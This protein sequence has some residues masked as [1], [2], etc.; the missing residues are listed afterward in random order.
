MLDIFN[1]KLIREQSVIIEGLKGVI[2]S[3]ENEKTK[4]EQRLQTERHDNE[5]LLQNCM[6]LREKIKDLENNIEVL[7]N[8]Y[9]KEEKPKRGRPKKEANK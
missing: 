9:M 5:I 1:K 8:T 7:R 3:L 4:L 6:E 2:N